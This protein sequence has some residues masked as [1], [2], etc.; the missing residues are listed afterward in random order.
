VARDQRYLSFTT[1][2]RSGEPVS[3]AVWAVPYETGF[4][5]WTSSGSGK[6]KRLAHTSR[7]VAQASDPRGRVRQGSVPVEG[8]ARTVTDGP[9]FEAVR[10]AIKEK[11]GFWTSVTKVLGSVGGFLRRKRIPYGDVV[12]IFRPD[13]PPAESADPT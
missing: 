13:E 3:T 7:A 11:Y 6:A 5:F 1:F 2:R 4:A 9:E 12:V 8:T 10:G